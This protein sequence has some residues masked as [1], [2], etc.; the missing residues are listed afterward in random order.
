MRRRDSG[1][2]KALKKFDEL[3]IQ[4]VIAKLDGIICEGCENGFAVV[5][6]ST[7]IGDFAL[8]RK[9][10]IKYEWLPYKKL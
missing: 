1:I 6:T 4:D 8:C 2:E 9:C 3:K 10:R 5:R 7:A